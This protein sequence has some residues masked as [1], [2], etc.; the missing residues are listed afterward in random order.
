MGTN[1]Y[2]KRTKRGKTPLGVDDY[3][4]DDDDPT[5]HLGKRSAAGLYCWD[6]RLP[7]VAYGDVSRVHTDG[8]RRA[9]CI[10]CGQS[11]AKNAHNAALVELGFAKPPMSALTGVQ[12][13]SSFSWAQDP[14]PVLG[15]CKKRPLAVLI[16]DE[17]DHD[18]TGASF[19]EMLEACPIRFFHSI[20]RWFC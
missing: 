8:E 18:Y 7:L 6:C 17:Y 1:F 13:A 4:V 11:E 14:A 12:G 20:G 3:G 2:W 5:I 15:L 16:V 9:T 10:Q 19:L